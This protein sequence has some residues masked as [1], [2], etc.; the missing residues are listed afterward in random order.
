[1]F[2]ADDH[3][4]I[5]EDIIDFGHHISEYKK[6]ILDHKIDLLIMNAKDEDQLAMHGMVYPLAIESRQIPLLML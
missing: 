2:L 3:P 4:V 1:M 6:L 5:I